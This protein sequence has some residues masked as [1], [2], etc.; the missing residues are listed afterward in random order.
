MTDI[1]LYSSCHVF[2]SESS[3]LTGGIINTL[4]DASN[5]EPFYSSIHLYQSSFDTMLKGGEA[6][7]PSS[8]ADLNSSSGF[9]IPGISALAAGFCS[10]FGDQVDGIL[11]GIAQAKDMLNSPFDL[12]RD[13][14]NGLLGEAASPLNEISSGLDSLADT[15]LG[16]IPP[17]PDVSELERI[18][19]ACGLLRGGLLDGI[20][21][22][23]ALLSGFLDQ[24][25]GMLDGLMSDALG[26][27]SSVLGL[28]E[29]G[30]AFILN[31]INKLLNMLNIG[32]L[33][34][35]LDGLINCIEAICGRSFNIPTTIG[36]PVQPT[37]ERFYLDYID[38]TMD[39]VNNMLNDM[40]LNDFGEFEPEKMFAEFENIPT[41][42]FDNITSIADTVIEESKGAEEMMVALVDDMAPVMNDLV[43]ELKEAADNFPGTSDEMLAVIDSSQDEMLEL[44]TTLEETVDKIDQD[45]LLSQITS[46][47]DDAEEILN[48]VIQKVQNMQSF[49]T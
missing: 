40:N 6:T 17:L 39:Y 21:D 23:L 13:E 3:D 47:K 11:G 41:E 24:L 18:M 29:A 19:Q 9:V 35:K 46:I 31:E 22:P 37:S 36:E 42:V 25:L 45:E 5:D 48:P 43:D 14:L 10:D 20:L 1:I 27:L 33:L 26:A 16:A 38:D 15:A 4:L 49:F 28:I 32:N 7:M 34:S 8:L 2:S 30:A 44:V 12:L